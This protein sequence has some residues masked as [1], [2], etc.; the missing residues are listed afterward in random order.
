[1]VQHSSIDHTGLTGVSTVSYASNVNRVDVANVGG[2][3]STVTRG[4]HV[5]L[6]VTS[7]SH[8]SNTFSGPVTL[9][10]Q[11]TL[12]ITSPSS[13]TFA[14]SAGAGTGGGG[15]VATDAIWTTAGKVAV[16]TGTATAT[17]QWPPGYEWDYSQITTSGA[18][19]ATVEASST[20]IIT[21][22][23]KTYDGAPVVARVFFP[24]ARPNDSAG[25]WMVVSLFEG[26]TQLGRLCW[27]SMPTTLSATIASQRNPLVGEFRFTP[28]AASHT[29]IVKSHVSTGTGYLGAGAGGTAALVPAFLRI[30][31]V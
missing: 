8:T 4:D 22:N 18:P 17:E 21:G 29:Y 26:A 6:G 24:D 12:G 5:H 9:V 20:T 28:T 30:T 19:T 13:G 16:A 23:A 1:M 7:L 15:S 2:A 27:M 3:A 14:L 11:G 10:A 25:A 31:K